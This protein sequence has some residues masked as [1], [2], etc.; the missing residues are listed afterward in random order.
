MSELL[1]KVDSNQVGKKDVQTGL[2]ETERIEWGLC[3]ATMTTTITIGILGGIFL[4]LIL[5]YWLPFEDLTHTPRSYPNLS[6][7]FFCGSAVI[8]VLSFFK[9]KRIFKLIREKE[10]GG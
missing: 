2:H 1:I 6:L 8:S 7:F 9:I 10:Y 5:I 4:G 3:I